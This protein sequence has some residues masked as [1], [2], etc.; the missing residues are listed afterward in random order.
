MQSEE[1]LVV[2]GGEG[3]TAEM[4]VKW[5]GMPLCE[6]SCES[7]QKIEN[8]FPELHLEDKVKTMEDG[9]GTNIVLKEKGKSGKF[10]KES[11]YALKDES[12]T[13]TIIIIAHRLS[14]AKA[15]DKIF[16]MDDGGIIEMGDHEE[17]MLKD[18]LYAKLNKIQANILT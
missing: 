13:R 10:T 15:A 8:Y 1:I 17:L 7:L 2:R 18:G 5:K 11:L 6:N 14:T 12:K 9:F 16:V 3:K 4:L